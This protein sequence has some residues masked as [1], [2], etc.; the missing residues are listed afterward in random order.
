MSRKPI[1]NFCR[2]TYNLKL[3]IYLEHNQ[4][5]LTELATYSNILPGKRYLNIKDRDGYRNA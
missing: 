2:K 5:Q 3:F 1:K 4:Q